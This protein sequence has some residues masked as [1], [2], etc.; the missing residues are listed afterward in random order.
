MLNRVVLLLLLNGGRCSQRDQQTTITNGYGA[1]AQ[2][3]R[4]GTLL[5]KTNKF[6]ADVRFDRGLTVL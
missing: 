6:V 1:G 2:L 5:Q 3:T 4:S